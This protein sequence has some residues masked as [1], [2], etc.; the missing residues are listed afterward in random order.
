MAIRIVEKLINKGNVERGWLG[1]GIQ[2]LN[3]ELAISFKIPFTA[4][5]KI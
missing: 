2:G 4:S 1:A 3:P 5:E